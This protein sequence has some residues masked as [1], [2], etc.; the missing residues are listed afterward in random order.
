MMTIEFLPAP[1]NSVRGDE[2]STGPVPPGRRTRWDLVEIPGGSRE[3]SGVDGPGRGEAC[4]GAR[5][6]RGSRASLALSL[7]DQA[8]YER[9]NGDKF[10]GIHALRH[11]ELFEERP[12]AGGGVGPEREGLEAE[13]VPV[14]A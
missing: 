9:A 2:A 4:L 1:V 7:V 13:R 10:F 14:P 3:P 6:G 11:F 8:L 12:E 5:D